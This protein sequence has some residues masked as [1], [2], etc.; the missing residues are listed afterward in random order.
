MACS[1]LACCITGSTKHALSAIRVIE[2]HAL[3]RRRIGA[4]DPENRRCN[5]AA[6]TWPTPTGYRIPREAEPVQ[7]WTGGAAVRMATFAV[8]WRRIARI[9]PA[10]GRLM[11]EA[12]VQPQDIDRMR[13]GQQAGM[14]RTE[15]VH[16]AR[17]LA[18]ACF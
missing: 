12:K 6:P 3:S 13:V 7:G 2:G 11:V 16:C 10:A 9:A 1:S 8:C 15:R 4:M 18:K 5:V 14:R 17:A